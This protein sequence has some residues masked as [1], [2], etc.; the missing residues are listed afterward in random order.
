MTG[1]SY[2]KGPL[3][4]MCAKLKGATFIG[5][6]TMPR[7]EWRRI[8]TLCK[9]ESAKAIAGQPA[10]HARDEREED[11]EFECEK[12]NGVVVEETP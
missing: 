11:I 8:S 3:F 4:K 9:E 6:V 12:R 1:A 5:T 7:E 10:S 2:A